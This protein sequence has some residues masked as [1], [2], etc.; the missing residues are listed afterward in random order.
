MQV[1]V[2]PE[3][4]ARDKEGRYYPSDYYMAALDLAMDCA[5]AEGEIYLAPANSFGAHQTEEY[6]GYDYLM[7]K[8]CRCRVWGLGSGVQGEGYLDTLDNAK[9]LKKYLQEKGWW[10]MGNITLVCNRPHRLRSVLM[11]RMFGFCIAEV[12][13][14]RPLQKT[15]HRMVKRL[16]FYDLP[17]LQYFYELTATVYNV[18]RF[19]F[20]KD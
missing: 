19:Y 17:I 16:W 15:G 14:S 10:P 2:V 6:F 1:V 8:G 20:E 13:T 11:F 7:S 9:Y 18:G 3:G 5:G 4:L 12:H